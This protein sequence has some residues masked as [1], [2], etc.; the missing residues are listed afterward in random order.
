MVARGIFKEILVSRLPVGHTHE[1][2]DGIF[3]ILWKNSRYQ[4]ILTPEQYKKVV[5]DALGKL[6][7][8]AEVVDIY[9]VPDYVKLLT[10]CISHHIEFLFSGEDT[11]HQ[12][13]FT[14]VNVSSDY[15]FG[16]KTEYKMYCQDSFY[17]IVPQV[18]PSDLLDIGYIPLLVNNE[19]F[20]SFEREDPLKANVGIKSNIHFLIDL[21]FEDI[22]PAPFVA[23]VSSGL[24]RTLNKFNKTYFGDKFTIERNEIKKFVEDLMPQNDDVT[25]YLCANPE[26]FIIPD[27][28][29][30]IFA[31]ST[32]NVVDNDIQPVQVSHRTFNGKPIIQVKAAP[33]VKHSGNRNSVLPMSLVNMD[34]SPLCLAEAVSSTNNVSTNSNYINTIMSFTDKDCPINERKIKEL[35]SHL[36]LSTSGTKSEL[37]LRLQQ[38]Y[39]PTIYD[40]VILKRRSNQ[41]PNPQVSSGEVGDNGV[42]YTT[43]TKTELYDILKSRNPPYAIS[44]LKK[45][46]IID[47]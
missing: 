6:S 33:S 41:R 39:R 9:A 21:P 19:W 42:T 23:G 8:P 34:G 14:K 31:D 24:N 44:K 15:P 38:F 26:L 3:G 27:I 11:Q 36:Q 10:P 18:N 45:D 5:I 7:I 32:I 2:C 28:A 1:D 25:N 29:K 12:W 43:K 47:K 13:K 46:E 30:E 17:K 37:L 16:V 35:L 4:H 40:S 22:Q 20:G